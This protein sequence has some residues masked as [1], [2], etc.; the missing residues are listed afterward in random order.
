M[1]LETVKVKKDN[2]KGYAI[3]NKSDFDPKVHQV[4]E[5]KP[6]QPNQPEQPK[7]EPK[8]Q[9]KKPTSKG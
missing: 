1:R 3:I 6:A 4:I 2:R 7:T 9:A 8:Q 5:E